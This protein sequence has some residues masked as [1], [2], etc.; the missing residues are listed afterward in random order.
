[1]EKECIVC[2]KKFFKKETC[3][4]PERGRRKYCSVKCKNFHLHKGDIPWNKGLTKEDDRVK[5]YCFNDGNFTRNRVVNEN[6]NKWKGDDVGYYGLHIWI[7]NHFGKPKK[8]EKCNCEDDKR[9]HWHNISGDYKRDKDD[10]IR[11]C[12]SC[13]KKLHLTTNI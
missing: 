13:H 10:W 6:N 9:Y 1:M 4:M 3:G 12:P 7:A 2:G 11:L 8:C 5:K